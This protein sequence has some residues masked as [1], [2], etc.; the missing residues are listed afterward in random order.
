MVM[1]FIHQMSDERTGYWKIKEIT[2][3][4]SKL[5]QNRGVDTKN[6]LT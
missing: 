6:R 2:V 4:E 5:G 1:I 3:K